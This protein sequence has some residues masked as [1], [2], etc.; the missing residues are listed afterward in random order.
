MDVSRAVAAATV[1]FILSVTLAS[2]PLVGL[3]LTQEKKQFE[4]GT[5]TI[6]ATVVSTPDHAT[7]EAA[8]YNIEKYHLR[9]QPVELQI[10]GATGQPTLSYEIFIEELSYTRS[11]V[12]FLDSS[13]SGTYFLEFEAVRF[14][15]DRIDRDQYNGLL[16]I[17]VVDQDRT[18][19]ETEIR[20]EVTE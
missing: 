17:V 13:I 1:T 4:P 16:R 20:I 15:A 12:T 5:G 19:A 10:A 3:S 11:S 7:L 6:N 9:A 2:G 14:D 18:L 8:K